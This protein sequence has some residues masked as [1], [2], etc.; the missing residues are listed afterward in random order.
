MTGLALSILLAACSPAQDED[1]ER[2][3]GPMGVTDGPSEGAGESDTGDT[4]A[5]D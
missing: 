5:A 1:Y 3:T 2:P 4:G